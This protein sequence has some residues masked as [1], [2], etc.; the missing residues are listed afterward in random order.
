MA[1]GQRRE[2]ADHGGLRHGEGDTGSPEVQV[3]MLTRRIADLTEHLSAQARPPQPPRLLLLVGRRRRLLQYLAEKDITRYRVADRATRPAPIARRGEWPPGRSPV[4]V[5]AT[6]VRG[7][8]ARRRSR[9]TSR[10]AA[11]VLGSGPRDHD[12]ARALRSKTGR[13][14]TRVAA[15]RPGRQERAHP[16]TEQSIGPPRPC[17][18]RQRHVR[19][20]HHPL[21]D[22]PAGP[23]G[24][25]LRRRLPG[26]RDHGAVGHHRVQEPEGA[27]RLLPADGGRRG[28][29]VRRRADPRLVL[30]PRGPARARTRSSPAG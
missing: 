28:A 12:S 14:P 19:H 20:P 17:R 7:P 24:R 9:P 27:P 25:R 3:A 29:D 30:P 21:R 8:G 22:R 16:M 23:A 5:L 18:Y 2:E 4:R 1:L 11:P 10:T 13:G 6:A 26:R 15:A